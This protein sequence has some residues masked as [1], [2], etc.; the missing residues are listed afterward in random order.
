MKPVHN[1]IVYN[2]KLGQSDVCSFTILPNLFFYKAWDFVL[3]K[4]KDLAAW[5]AGNEY[6]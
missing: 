6:K 5:V 2:D 1:D 4:I 3:K